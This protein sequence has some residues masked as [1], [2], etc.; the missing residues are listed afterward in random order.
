M[1]V[2]AFGISMFLSAA[3]LFLVE[4]MIAKMMLPMLGGTPAV[5]NTC[6]VFFQAMLLLGYLY[7]HGVMKWLGR[8]PQMTLHLALAAFPLL[9]VGFVPPHL[10]EG[11]IPPDISSPIPWILAMLLVSVGLPFFVLSSNT[12]IMQ[13]WFADSGHP[14]AADPYFLYGAS[15]AGS[16]AGLLAYPLLLEP[17]M[18][19]GNQSRL[20]SYGYTLFVVLTG[21]CAALVWSRHS[22]NSDL[23][24]VE[25]VRSF[26]D[27]RWRQRLRWIALAFVPSS[28]MLGVT[29]ALTTDVPAIPFD[30]GFAAC[31]LPGELRT[32][33]CQAA[34][35]F[36]P[37]ADPKASISHRRRAH[38]RHIAD[39]ASPPRVSVAL[40]ST[41]LDRSDG[42]PRGIGQEQATGFQTHRVLSLDFRGRR[43]GRHL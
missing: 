38:P 6:L 40:S 41:P 30:L 18:R 23:A 11:S 32:G 35:R 13:R 29:T 26:S 42:L 16:L 43:A 5:W 21:A 37:M 14:Q 25:A 19:L 34:A 8:R 1:L 22:P 27:H 28:L 2:I 39:E 4:P 31:S 15:N 17:L 20:W 36:A 9:L 12:P 7:A 24:A 3:L 10:P 33:I